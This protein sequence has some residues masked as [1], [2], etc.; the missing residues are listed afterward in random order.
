MKAGILCVCAWCV[1]VW[2]GALVGV[3][4]CA[5]SLCLC[6]KGEKVEERQ[7]CMLQEGLACMTDGEDEGRLEPPFVHVK[8]SLDPLQLPTVDLLLGRNTF[9]QNKTNSLWTIMK[10][11]KF[12]GMNYWLCDENETVVSTGGG[13]QWSPPIELLPSTV[14]PTN[15]QPTTSSASVDLQNKHLP[16]VSLTKFGFYPT[17]AFLC[18]LN[19]PVSSNVEL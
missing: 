8:T 1:R 4:L 2:G 7:L 14:N 18:L 11:F 9:C 6:V 13:H 15:C 17:F 3:C 19:D 12:L 10:L 16:S 5:M